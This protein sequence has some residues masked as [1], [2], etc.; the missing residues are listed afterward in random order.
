[1]LGFRNLYRRGQMMPQMQ[2]R[3][4]SVSSQATVA[5]TNEDVELAYTHEQLNDQGLPPMIVLHGLLGTIKNLRSL[6][7]YPQIS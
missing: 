6:V 7:R 5:E 1:M 3:M 2:K 4:F